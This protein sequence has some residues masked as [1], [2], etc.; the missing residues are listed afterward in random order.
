MPD[1]RA[2]EVTSGARGAATAGFAGD[3]LWWLIGLAGLLADLSL[4][5]AAPAL[6]A[7]SALH[8]AAQWLS[9]VLLQPVLEEAVFRGILQGELLQSSWGRSRVLGLS[10]ANIVCSL[11]FAALH[12]LHHPPLWAL[13]VL[14]PSLILGGLRERHGTLA[15]PIA[16]HVLFNLAFFAAASLGVG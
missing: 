13:G 4:R 14:A 7:T 11:A 1:S 16:M 9:C 2:T 5:L 6:L 8:S 15:S 3:P 12:F 10:A